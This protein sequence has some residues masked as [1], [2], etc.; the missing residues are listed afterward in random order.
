[1]L[2]EF[3]CWEGAGGVTHRIAE[4]FVISWAVKIVLF[5]LLNGN[6]SKVPSHLLDSHE[7]GLGG[8]QGERR[9]NRY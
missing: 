2:L 6:R 1:M 9:D 7:D 4:I 5:V 8:G 3:Q